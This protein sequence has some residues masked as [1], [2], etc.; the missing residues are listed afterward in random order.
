GNKVFRA[1][2]VRH[3][4]RRAHEF[5]HLGHLPARVMAEVHHSAE[6]RE[7]DQIR[8]P[9]GDDLPPPP[10][11]CH[12]WPRL[13]LRWRSRWTYWGC[14]GCGHTFS[15]MDK[16]EAPFDLDTTMPRRESQ[17]GRGGKKPSEEVSVRPST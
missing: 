9:T 16:R 5:G 14:D 2:V 10:P 3:D 8:N 6:Q 11:W 7:D 15:P 4:G 12:G 13:G 1:P 17:T